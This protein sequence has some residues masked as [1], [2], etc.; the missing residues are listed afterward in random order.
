MPERVYPKLVADG[1]V[2]RL[3]GGAIRYTLTPESLVDV[4][5]AYGPPGYGGEKARRWDG[6]PKDALKYILWRQQMVELARQKIAAAKE[7]RLAR[8]QAAAGREVQ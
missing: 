6:P 3:P 5:E 8:A 1:P 2:E 7:R 4:W